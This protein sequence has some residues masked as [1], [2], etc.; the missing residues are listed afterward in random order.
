M[1]HDAPSSA[2]RIIMHLI[3]VLS[4]S[5]HRASISSSTV[6]LLCFHYFFSWMHHDAPAS[7]STSSCTRFQFSLPLHRASIPSY[8]GILASLSPRFFHT[9][10]DQ[11]LLCSLQR[12]SGSRDIIKNNINIHT[13]INLIKVRRQTKRQQ[14]RPDRPL[15]ISFYLLSFLSGQKR[16]NIQILQPVYVPFSTDSLHTFLLN[17]MA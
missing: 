10:P 13:I 16:P 2:L 11:N 3:S 8:V 17:V 7:L 14:M 12:T 9:V 15:L 1:H 4:S 6:S 5:M